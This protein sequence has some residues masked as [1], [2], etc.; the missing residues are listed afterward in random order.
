MTSS[1]WVPKERSE[2]FIAFGRENRFSTLNTAS[3]NEIRPPSQIVV[4][5]NY[6]TIRII[7]AITPVGL[8]DAFE[9]CVRARYGFV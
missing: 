9:I 4:Y 8:V 7:A 1:M 6:Y 2:W 3:L 5:A